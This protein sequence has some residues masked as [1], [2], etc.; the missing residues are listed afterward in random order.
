MRIIAYFSVLVA[1]FA[2]GYFGY[3]FIIYGEGVPSHYEELPI[4]IDKFLL[5]EQSEAIAFFISCNLLLRMPFFCFVEAE[6]TVDISVLSQERNV[7]VE[8]S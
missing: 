5:Q 3:S 1:M 6:G 8:Y 7:I 4:F 2:I